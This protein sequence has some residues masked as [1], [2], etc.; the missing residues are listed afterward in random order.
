MNHSI[1]L[2]GGE[3]EFNDNDEPDNEGIVTYSLAMLYLQSF[4]QPSIFLR[5]RFRRLASILMHFQLNRVPQLTIAHNREW[6][7]SPTSWPN[8]QPEGS[9]ILVI[10]VLGPLGQ[11]I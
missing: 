10:E 2:G 4:Y 1:N 7:T 9:N 5:Y 11:N 8:S 3:A 6:L